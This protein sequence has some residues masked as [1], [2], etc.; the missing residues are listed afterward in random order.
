LRPGRFRGIVALALCGCATLAAAQAQQYESDWEIKQKELDWKEG[1]FTLPAV[2]SGKG[3]IEFSVSAVNNFKFLVDPQS[4]SVGA[5]GVVRYAMVARSPA[6]AETVSFE[7]I[8]C[9]SGIFKVYAYVSG[10]A[11]KRS[12]SDWK[13]IEPQGRVQRWHN[14]LRDEYFCPKGNTLG[15]PAEAI[16]ALRRGG[17]PLVRRW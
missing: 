7:G 3:L 14:V 17:H 12:N 11:W 4:I 10:E 6:G 15:A 2:P 5:D 13:E 1:E 16:D 8:R 9:K